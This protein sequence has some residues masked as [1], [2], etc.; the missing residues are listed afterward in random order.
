MVNDCGWIGCC[1]HRD[2]SFIVLVIYAEPWRSRKSEQ[3]E[4]MD[5]PELF[6]PCTLLC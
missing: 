2:I 3:Q 1:V 4:S 5:T 6:L